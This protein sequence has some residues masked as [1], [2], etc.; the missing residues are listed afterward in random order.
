MLQHARSRF[1]GTWLL[2]GLAGIAPPTSIARGAEIDTA[3]VL[4]ADPRVDPNDFRITVFASGLDFPASPQELPDG[5]I[6]VAT[7]AR[8]G[9]SYYNSS[10]VLLRLVDADH[11]GDADGPGAIQ[12]SDLPDTISC[13][14]VAGSLVLVMSADPLAPTISV[15][16]RGASEADPYTLVGQ[17]VLSFPDGWSH[18]TYALALHETGVPGIYEVFFNVGSQV[19]F[20]AT[21]ATSTVT[22]T[23][24]LQGTL[25][26]DAIYR[27]TMHDDGIGIPAFS[28]L[29]QIATGLRNA[30]GMTVQPESGDLYFEDNGIDTPGH[31]IEAFS[32]D[33]LNF[34]PAATLGG[35]IEDF[36]FPTGYVIYRTG[37]V[38]G[39]GVQP[40]IA[41]QPLPDP[42]TG[43]ESEGAFEVAFAPPGFPA[44]L[45]DGMFIGFHGQG[46]LAGVANE[47]NPV[48]WVDPM[49]QQYFHFVLGR[50]PGLGH[51]DSVLATRDSLF[52]ADLSSAGPFGGTGFGSGVIHQIRAIGP[53]S[54][55]DGIV[56]SLDDCSSVPNASQL[57]ADSDGYGNACDPDLDQNGVVNAADLARL[58]S[59]FFKQD[60]IADLNGDG[61]VNAVDLAILKGSF[62]KKPGP[63]GLACAGNAGCGTP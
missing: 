29:E 20:A 40:I 7:S 45:R 2:T 15:L 39:A 17:I 26:G 19:N 52:V 36:G 16:R 63:S 28:G 49:S 6:L 43:A 1:F 55:G 41:F 44:A 42:Q 59:V 14:R 30:A 60:P 13:V 33:E 61:V 10:G 32:A 37:V 21:P 5:S 3:I 62:F 57:D 27:M 53:D 38:V 58:K 50:R 34:L 24:L 9:N 8:D 48:V 11:D 47:E 54:D 18:Q 4:A 25:N 51:P 35:T 22:A 56:D 46:S 12:A 23:G 31:G